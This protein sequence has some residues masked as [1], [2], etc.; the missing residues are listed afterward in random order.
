MKNSIKVILL[1]VVFFIQI[2]PSFAD[3][4]ADIQT[5]EIGSLTHNPILF[6]HGWKRSSLDFDTLKL[7]LK[8]D[9]WPSTNL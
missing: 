8:T 9:G 5:S 4:K 2:S 6:I 3:H 7:W 1:I